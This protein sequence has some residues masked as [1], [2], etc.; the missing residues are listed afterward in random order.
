[1]YGIFSS[2]NLQ[3]FFFRKRNF[4]RNCFFLVLSRSLG[5]IV[6]AFLRSPPRGR[7]SFGLACLRG[8][9]RRSRRGDGRRLRDVL[10]DSNG[11]ILQNPIVHP[12]AP[13][14][15]LRGRGRA[16]HQNQRVVPVLV[17]PHAVG[18][19]PLPP[20]LHLQDLSA[21]GGDALL[22]SLAQS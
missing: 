7:S 4:F 21:R 20:P 11:E 10:V 8:R 22:A 5:S 17:A 2:Q 13:L 9:F 18:E 19:A 6:T 1:M 15:L 16:F 12:I 3:N 14:K